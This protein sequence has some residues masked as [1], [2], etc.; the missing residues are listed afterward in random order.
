MHPTSK[1][2]RVE[3]SRRMPIGMLYFIGVDF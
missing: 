3:I 2:T 1:P